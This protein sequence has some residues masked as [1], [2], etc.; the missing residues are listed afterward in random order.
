MNEQGQLATGGLYVY[1]PMSVKSCKVV[2]INMRCRRELGSAK[3]SMETAQNN[4]VM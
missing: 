4:E 3:N 1:A 2:Y